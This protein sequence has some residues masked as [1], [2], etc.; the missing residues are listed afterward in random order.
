[1][2]LL[3]LW[4]ILGVHVGPD[5][6]VGV[7]VIPELAQVGVLVDEVGGEAVE[8]AALEP[9]EQ[10]P[11][12][13]VGHGH[14]LAHEEPSGAVVLEHLVQGRE[15]EGQLPVVSAQLGPGRLFLLGVLHAHGR[16]HRDGHVGGRVYDLIDLG[17]GEVIVLSSTDC[18]VR[19]RATFRN[20]V[21]Y[22]RGLM[23][24]V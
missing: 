16:P 19:K 8:D 14:G 24:G 2:G 23:S 13:D 11:H 1:M 9:A 18:T 4:G 17:R 7:H 21:L 5:V 12:G 6:R 3:L 10:P 20:R 15:I 22:D